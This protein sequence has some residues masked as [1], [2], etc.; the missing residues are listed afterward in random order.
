M[1]VWDASVRT[2]H[3][4]LVAAVS[5]AWA[6]TLGLGLFSLHEPAGYLASFIV[7]ARLV[8]GFAGSPYA[9]FSQFVRGPIQARRYAS[10]LVRKQEPRY[11]G[12]NPLGGWMVLAL[13]VVILAT[14]FT[15]WLYTTDEFWGMAWLD[16]LHQFLAWTLLGL[17]ALHLAGVVFTS[18]R[19]GENLV[20]A[21]V[22]G[23]KA[24]PQGDDVA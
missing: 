10:L 4:A 14:G 5:L 6:S 1:K 17:I 16:Q 12:H 8:W 2:L 13:L 20:R 23:K 9:R 24:P 3:W 19:H 7:F 21:M 15:G 18:V 22:T 11:I